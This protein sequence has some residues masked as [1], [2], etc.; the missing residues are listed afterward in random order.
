MFVILIPMFAVAQSIYRD[1]PV[2]KQLH[3]SR[4]NRNETR[5][6]D[7]NIQS[8]ELGISYCGGFGTDDVVEFQILVENGGSISID[9]DSLSL[10]EGQ[11]FTI[12]RLF[13][14]AHECLSFCR[15]AFDEV[16]GFPVDIKHTG[17]IE[18]GSRTQVLSF[19][20]MTGEG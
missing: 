12:D 3:D 19:R 20:P 11:Q 10:I 4:V 17:F 18:S 2:L 14:A 7:Q 9:S 5:W 1:I 6:Q 15:V 8:Y 13:T 16:F